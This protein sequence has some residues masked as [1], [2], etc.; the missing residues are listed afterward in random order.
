MVT[1]A[2]ILVYNKIPLNELLKHVIDLCE[3]SVK[4][5]VEIEFAVTLN[6]TRI[7]LLQVRPL[8]A[9]DSEITISDEEYSSER[10][11]LRSDRVLGNGE[12]NTVE[13]VLYVKPQTFNAKYTLEIAQEI[14]SINA[15]FIENGDHYVLIGFGRWGSS[16]PWLGTP[17]TWGQISQ[18]QTI[19]ESTLPD[20]DKEFSQGSHFFH[21]ITSFGVSYFSVRHTDESGIDWDWLAMQTS[22]IETEHVKLVKLEQPLSIKIDGRCGRGVIQK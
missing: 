2:P 9:T 16:D 8:M 21:N 10:A 19:V 6:P 5:P 4:S 14:E 17:V 1:F 3:Q 22:V 18:A 12:I 13:H 7:G 20:M 11:L 15:T